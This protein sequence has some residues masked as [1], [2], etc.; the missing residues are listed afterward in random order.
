MWSPFDKIVA[1]IF[2]FLPDDDLDL[3]A[4][5]DRK[6]QRSL[7]LTTYVDLVNQLPLPPKSFFFVLF[8]SSWDSWSSR[9]LSS[10]RR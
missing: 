3:F 4:E 5:W 6:T 10:E 7:K 2:N 8:S 9:P 1:G